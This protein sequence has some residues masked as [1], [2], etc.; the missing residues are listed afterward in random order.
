MTSSPT[1]STVDRGLRGRAQVG[2]LASQEQP[3]HQMEGATLHVDG[4]VLTTHFVNHRACANAWAI[5]DRES[6]PSVPLAS[7]TWSR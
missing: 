6:R 2:Y 4:T 3:R 7:A 1:G 5:A